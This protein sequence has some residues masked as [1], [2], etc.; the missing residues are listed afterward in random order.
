MLAEGRGEER[1]RDS[2]DVGFA[3][4]LLSISFVE[5]SV[6]ET[7]TTVLMSGTSPRCS[8]TRLLSNTKDPRRLISTMLKLPESH[9]R[10]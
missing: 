7:E 8:Q 10:M 9:S 4:T 6:L 1:D 2:G 3:T 5:L